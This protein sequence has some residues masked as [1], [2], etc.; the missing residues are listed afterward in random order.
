M[1][2]S[3]LLLAVW[4]GLLAPLLAGCETGTIVRGAGS[5]HRQAFRVG[6]AF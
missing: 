5:E 4:L 6:L 2:R 1:A 3:A